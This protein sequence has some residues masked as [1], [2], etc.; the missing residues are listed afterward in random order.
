MH[1]RV[2]DG[3]DPE[4]RRAPAPPPVAVDGQAALALQLQQ[5]A[6]NRATTQMLQRVGVMDV[7]APGLEAG[8]ELL[9]WKGFVRSNRQTA[10]YRAIDPAW[11][12]LAGEY[13]AA[14]PEDGKWIRMGVL[15]RPD[16]WVGG[17]ILVQA[18]SA[19]HAITLDDDVFFNPEATGEPNVD[20]YVHELVHVAQYGLL[21]I[22]GFLGT[23]A[24]EFVK[25]YVG[26]G[27]DDTA[28]Y[29]QIAHEQQAAAIE[30]RFKAWREAKEKKD[31]EDE[32]KKPTPLDPVKEAQD[33]MRGPSPISA[34]GAFGLGGSV[35]AQGDNRP[36]DVERVAGRLHALGFLDPMT[37]D[38]DAVAEAIE[39]YQGRVV[40]QARP[41]G[42]VDVGKATH[43]ALKAGR[44]TVSM[45]LE[46]GGR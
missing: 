30:A 26:S 38:V 23:Y 41:D 15:R 28:A 42:R 36:A 16:F 29:H 14:H 13:S 44:K 6:G 19:T 21:G 2:L 22:T 46:R 33:A 39:D 34:T 3:E 10:A 37:T 11:R 31:A 7:I 12:Q 9:A 1:E 40:G 18:G 32:A 45:Q 24:G 5:S 25:G 35:G 17:W 8:F 43:Q 4:R 20:T 27:G